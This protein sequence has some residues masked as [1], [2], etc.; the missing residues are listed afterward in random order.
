[1]CE[2]WLSYVVTVAMIAV[3]LAGI[4]GTV[5]GRLSVC[6]VSPAH[7]VRMLA[8]VVTMVMV[9]AARR[10]D[11]KLMILSLTMHVHTPTNTHTHTHTN[12]HKHTHT[13][14]QSETAYIRSPSSWPSARPA[15]TSR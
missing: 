8:V 10:R 1:M 2:T 4:A 9:M 12:A 14:T 13:H 3:A 7:V 15:G 6:C 5:T 11:E